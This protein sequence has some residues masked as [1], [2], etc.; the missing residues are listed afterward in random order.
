MAIR[1]RGRIA[2]RPTARTARSAARPGRPRA[3][4]LAPAHLGE[5][6]SAALLVLAT[7]GLAVFIAALAMI[8]FG[9]TMP[10]RFGSSP[11]PN[12]AELGFGQVFGGIGLLLLGVAMVG[13][14]LAVLAEVRGSRRV[15]GGVAAL[16]AILSVGGVVATL[17]QPGQELVLPL[18]LG[19]A[20]L[21]FLG[22]A[23]ILLRPRP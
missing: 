9:L 1:S 22:V 11:P 18:A 4:S 16:A 3:H 6:A 8:V 23:V 15:A 14:S 7:L 12:V 21:I 17:L 20:A 13:S 2:A 19:L 5:A 10:G